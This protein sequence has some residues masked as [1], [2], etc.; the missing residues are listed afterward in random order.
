M[1]EHDFSGYKL[2]PG[3]KQNG[4][5]VYRDSH[6]VEKEAYEQH[7][8]DYLHEQLFSRLSNLVGIVNS[9]LYEKFMFLW[10]LIVD[11]AVQK[12]DRTCK[13]L[14]E[15]VGMITVHAFT[16][17]YPYAGNGVPVNVFLEPATAQEQAE[18]QEEGRK[19]A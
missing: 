6:G 9:D 15:K 10:E 14:D 3:E 19:A 5:F 11:D 18:P 12:L 16:A 17:D 8:V 4:H 2:V 1:D 13:L 7:L